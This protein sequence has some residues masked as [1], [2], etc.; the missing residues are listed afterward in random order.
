MTNPK[1]NLVKSSLQEYL[2]TEKGKRICDQKEIKEIINEAGSLEEYK[3]YAK[4]TSK[5][6]ADNKGVQLNDKDFEPEFDV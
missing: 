2:N 6:F 1:E 5:I 3:Q 4:N